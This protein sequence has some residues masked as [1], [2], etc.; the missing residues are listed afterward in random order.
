[1]LLLTLNVVGSQQRIPLRGNLTS[2]GEIFDLQVAAST[3]VKNSEVK[4][5]ASGNTLMEY[6]VL[7]SN[8]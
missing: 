1:M 4:N 3:A 6:G 7:G 2:L 8:N 5:P